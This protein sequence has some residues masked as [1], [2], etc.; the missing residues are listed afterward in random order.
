M[1]WFRASEQYQQH[2]LKRGRQELLDEAIGSIG[3]AKEFGLH[4]NFFMP[5]STRTTLD[6]LRDAVQAAERAGADEVTLVDSLSIARP[7]ALAS[8]EGAVF[9]A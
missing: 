7:A 6:Q 3:R 8:A 5:E 2:V 1:V 4:A 9:A